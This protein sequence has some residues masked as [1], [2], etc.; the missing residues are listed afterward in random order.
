MKSTICF[1]GEC[2]WF[3]KTYYTKRHEIID[4]S[5]IYMQGWSSTYE[6]RGFCNF[7]IYLRNILESL[8]YLLHNISIYIVYY[9]DIEF[10]QVLSAKCGVVP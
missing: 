8:I 6:E 5:I 2:I 7:P 3:Q 4:V 1:L 9:I 10:S